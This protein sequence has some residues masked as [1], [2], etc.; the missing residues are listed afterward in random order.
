MHWRSRVLVVAC[1]GSLAAGTAGAADAAPGP[2]A[3]PSPAGAERHSVTLLTGDVVQVERQP[4]GKQ[5]AT[6]QP[7]PG[8]EKIR[9][10]QQ[11]LD[12]HLSVFPEDV[13]PRL[14]SKQVDRNL[15][16]VTE[17]IAE[18]YADEQSKTL[19]L[20]LTYRKGADLRAA[21]A[22]PKAAELGATLS[23][24]NGRSARASKADAGAFWA[25]SAGSAIER[26]SLDRKVRA[27]LDRSVPQIGAPEAWAAG[28]DGTGSTV[29]VLDT[30]YDPTHP[31]L[32]GR[33]VASANFTDAATVTDGN[34]HGTHVASTVGGSGAASSGLRKGVAPGAQLMVGKVLDDAGTGEDSWVLAGMTWAVAQGADVVS[35]S[36]GGDTG[37]GTDP[38]SQAVDEL[39]ASSDTLFVI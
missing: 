21:E 36:L 25:S 18:G 31:D 37:D 11:E 16:D 20:I 30:G 26:I 3:A 29:A 2:A 33:V 39:S 38:L 7:A 10:H 8:R 35:M 1:V 23:S 13:A 34:G 14:G 22:A 24:V 32:A 6:V 19:P 27:S 4:G 17:L 5:A 12:G 28:Y 15:F 9:F